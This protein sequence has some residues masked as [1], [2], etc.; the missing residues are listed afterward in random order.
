MGLN[1]T[2]SNPIAEPIPKNWRE[3][4]T[5]TNGCTLVFVRH[6]SG[7]FWPW[8]WPSGPLDSSQIMNH[9][10]PSAPV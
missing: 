5:L 10:V 8:Q 7:G 4:F 6:V 3:S 9:F 1:R 2:V